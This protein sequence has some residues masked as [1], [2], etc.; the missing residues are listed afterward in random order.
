M[1]PYLKEQYGNA[2]AIH[3][4]GRSARQAVEVAR[5]QIARSI[6]WRSEQVIFTGSGTES[7]NL[8]VLGYLSALA[9]AGREY[10]SMEVLMTKIDH[11]SLLTLGDEL[12]SRGVV[13]RY[14]PVTEEG[15]VTRSAVQ[16]LLTP[17]TVLVALTYVNSE[18]GTIQPV[19][20]LVRVIRAYAKEV[21]TAIWTHLDAAQAPLWLSCYA[22]TLGVDSLTFDAGKC[23]GPKGVGMLAVRSPEQLRH[24]LYGGGQERG[25]RPGTENVAGVVG[26]AAAFV[27]AQTD[28]A[29]RQ[30][31]VAA[32][33]EEAL[34]LLP[35]IL[36]RAV[37]NGASGDERVANNINLT[38]P[39]IDTEYAVVWLDAHGV[40]ASTKSACVGAGSGVSRVV[41]VCTGDEE[42]ARHT[43]RLTLGEE[44]TIEDL[45]YVF[46]ILAAL[47][48]KLQHLTDL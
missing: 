16:Q 31:R 7:N 33:R 42:R 34:A 15:I 18:I 19:S 5:Q 26:A 6:G 27:A 4:E 1:E 37:I 10:A 8:A 45:R 2:S 46:Q 44:T 12:R 22:P 28:V 21:G 30:E 36:P 23:G 41:A 3:A 9:A 17:Q 20:S 35:T 38:L 43:L 25:L 11:P 14:I 39:S 24:I 13:V 48:T 47:Q 40:A 29:V 32:V